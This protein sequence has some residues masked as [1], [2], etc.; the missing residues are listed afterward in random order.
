MPQTINPSA[1]H[2]ERFLVRIA[3]ACEI[4]GLTQADAAER[5]G[6]T[7][8]RVNKALA[9]ARKR[10]LVKVSINSQFSACAEAEFEIRN[11]FALDE[12]H[13][14]PLSD[15][16]G[17]VKELIGYYLGQ[18]LDRILAS[19]SI[20]R[21]GLGWGTTLNFAMQHMRRLNRSDMEIM[22][23]MGCVTRASDVNII[24]STRLLANLCNAQKRYFTAPLYATSKKSRD[25]VIK[26][27][28]FRQM[29]DRI[30]NVDALAMTVGDASSMSDMIRD[31][32]PSSVTPQDL[33]DAGAVGDALGY[34]LDCNGKPIDHS[35]NGCVIGMQLADLGNIPNVILAAGGQH[36]HRIIRAMLSLDLVNTLITDQV[37]AEYLLKNN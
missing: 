15:R 12:V 13:V 6:V 26:Q 31:G 34:Y 8:L 16:H 33:V 4:E 11:R 35:I 25:T 28:V 18:Y 20:Q 21:F 17:T 7:R 9:E 22:S 36:K 24:E 3:W 27:E 14:A 29:L 30:R 1:E 19:S 23:V 2:E 37:T 5:F 32:L 10:G